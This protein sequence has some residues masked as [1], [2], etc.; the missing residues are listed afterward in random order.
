MEALPKDVPRLNTWRL[1]LTEQEAQQ[2]PPGFNTLPEHGT[3]AQQFRDIDLMYGAVP[4]A[5]RAL[6]RP[7]FDRF[8][9]VPEVCDA[10]DQHLHAH[11]VDRS[12]L[13][14]AVHLRLNTFTAQ[15]LDGRPVQDVAGFIEKAA[16]QCAVFLRARDL[17]DTDLQD[18]ANVLVTTDDSTGNA[19]KLFC[20]VLRGMTGNTTNLFP[21]V[22]QGSQTCR[23]REALADMLLISR[24]QTIVATESSTFT[25]VAWWL[26][27]ARA[28]VAVIPWRG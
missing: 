14:V 27:G 6:W 3:D 9:P 22:S 26:G 12:T 13:H 23:L 16:L 25:E 15:C 17:Q 5:I 7:I 10:V 8:R 4:D 20:A 24:A 2:M 18:T 19:F 21:G 1:L 11:G 28:N